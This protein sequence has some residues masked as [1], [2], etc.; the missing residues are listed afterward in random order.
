MQDNL[1]IVLIC[2]LRTTYIY[3]HAECSDGDIRLVGGSVSY[4]G[5]V[6]CCD[7]GLWGTVCD[8]GWKELDAEVACTQLGYPPEGEFNT[9]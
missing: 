9:A 8:D 7:G 3:M 6:E 4:E 2:T 1:R 5:R